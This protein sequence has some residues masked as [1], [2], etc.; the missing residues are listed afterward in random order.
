MENSENEKKNQQFFYF[1]L[2]I[3]LYIYL[4]QCGVILRFDLRYDT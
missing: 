4:G 3:Y 1:L 2:D